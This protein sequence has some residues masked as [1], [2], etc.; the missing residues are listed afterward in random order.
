MRSGYTALS[1][2]ALRYA[3]A[4]GYAWA[5]LSDTEVKDAYFMSFAMSTLYHSDNNVRYYAL[6]G[7]DA[8]RIE[9]AV[10]SEGFD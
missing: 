9:R 10:E 8:G 5:G 6:P 1:Y 3:G 4:V 2:E 7:R